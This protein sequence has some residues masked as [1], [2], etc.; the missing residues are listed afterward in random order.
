MQ[1]RLT[2][3]SGIAAEMGELDGSFMEGNT[4]SVLKALGKQG[5]AVKPY[6]RGGRCM[7]L[8]V[9]GETVWRYLKLFNVREGAD[10]V[11]VAV[12][13]LEGKAKD[14]WDNICFTEQ[15]KDIIDIEQLLHALQIQ[16]RPL[17]E[18]TKLSL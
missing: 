7:T 8:K 3:S 1:Q 11:T 15:Q 9:W 6:D 14:W 13:F 18:D 16:F 17:N 2:R 5:V 12:C 10:Q 4:L